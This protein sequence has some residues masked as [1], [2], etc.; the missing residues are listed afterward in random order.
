MISLN[1]ILIILYLF[2]SGLLITIFTKENRWKG[3]L[4]TSLFF[5]YLLIGYKVILLVGFAYLIY[6]FS[7]SVEKN[8][9]RIGIIV[10]MLL[11]PLL[12]SKITNTNTHF[13]NYE[14]KNIQFS[15]WLNG[16]TIFR[17]IGL[18]YFTFNGISYLIDEVI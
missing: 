10:L 3:L 4:I 17:I 7:F 5:Y 12:L 18:S 13:E 15:A 8:K 16:I 9:K 6:R 14:A 1:L 11:L 2:V